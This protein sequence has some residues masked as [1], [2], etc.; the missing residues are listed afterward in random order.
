MALASRLATSV[1]CVVEGVAIP[2]PRAISLIPT[3]ASI[4]R[5]A[6]AA[7]S[8]APV[9]RV[10]AAPVPGVSAVG[11]CISVPVPVSVSPPRPVAF[12]S[13]ST[14]VSRPR[15]ASASPSSLS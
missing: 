15:P 14:S 12:L 11:C 6:A 4:A 2:A 3:P 13:P 8:L 9:A 10:V 1:S 7:V 5:G